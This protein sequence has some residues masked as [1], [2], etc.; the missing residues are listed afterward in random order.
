MESGLIA[1]YMFSIIALLLAAFI[2][3]IMT[4]VHQARRS[5][6]VWFVLTIV[7]IPLIL[8][9]YWFIWLIVPEFR[10]TKGRRR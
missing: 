3:W 10:K 4:L 7:G 6:W 1:T 5:R 8:P 2:I 9:L